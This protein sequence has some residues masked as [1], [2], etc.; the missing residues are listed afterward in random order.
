[1]CL[2]SVRGGTLNGQTTARGGGIGSL[3]GGELTVNSAWIKDIVGT[4]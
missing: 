2:G 1:V 4:A 3:R